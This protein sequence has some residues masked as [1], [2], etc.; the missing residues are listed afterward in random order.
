MLGLGFDYVEGRRGP[1]FDPLTLFAAGEQGGWYDPSLLTSMYQDSAGTV[2]AA[3][4]APVGRIEDRSGRGN[5][6]GQTVAAARP[7]LRQAAGLNYLEYDG[8]DDSLESPA[9]GLRILGDLTLAAGT[10]KNGGGSYGA[11]LSCQTAPGAVNAYE[12]RFEASGSAAQLFFIAANSVIESDKGLGA[13][14]KPLAT[15]LAV[16]ARRAIGSN[17]E[18]MANGGAETFAHTL[19]PTADAGSVF[20]LGNR[21]DNFTPLAGR[22]YGA[23]AIARRLS[24]AELGRLT[25][26]F[27]AKAG[28]AF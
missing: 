25:T 9:A 10:Y 4:D 22:I 28:A 1:A 8:V 2:A 24:D 13:S 5:H 11:L 23:L 26:H 12:L 6:L 7:I 20:R 27:A 19:V 17:V 21:S 18:L 15:P 16:S 14:L 3:V